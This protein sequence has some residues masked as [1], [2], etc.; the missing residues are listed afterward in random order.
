MKFTPDLST[1]PR[2]EN[3][4]RKI[5]KVLICWT[6]FPGVPR[7]FAFPSGWNNTALCPLCNIKINSNHGLAAFTTASL[8]LKGWFERARTTAFLLP[9][10]VPRQGSPSATFPYRKPRLRQRGVSQG[11]SRMST[12][13]LTSRFLRGPGPPA[14]G[15]LATRFRIYKC[16]QASS[17]EREPKMLRR[18]FLQ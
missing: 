3:L 5:G 1:T 11:L 18:L 15:A 8:L 6:T 14:N 13:V 10:R 12:K 2:Y 9:S 7:L 17:A 16:S 4:F